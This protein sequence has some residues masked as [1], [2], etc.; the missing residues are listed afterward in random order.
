MVSFRNSAQARWVGGLLR[1]E[2]WK[3]KKKRSWES[4]SLFLAH[5]GSLILFDAI[6]ASGTSMTCNLRL[7]QLGAVIATLD[8]CGWCFRIGRVNRSM[9]LVDA[10]PLSQQEV[11]STFYVNLFR[12]GLLFSVRRASVG[13]PFYETGALA[14]GT[15]CVVQSDTMVVASLVVLV[16]AD[17][18][19]QIPQ[20]HSARPRRCPD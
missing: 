8:N 5:P 7:R 4:E 15:V 1:L 3:P 17:E 9:S 10:G 6:D 20:P 19:L 13:F 2:G 14:S 11:S 16:I 12:C 18:D